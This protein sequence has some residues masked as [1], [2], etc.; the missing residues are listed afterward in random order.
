MGVGVGV[1]V[2][3]VSDGVRFRRGRAAPPPRYHPGMKLRDTLNVLLSVAL[4]AGCS[5]ADADDAVGSEVEASPSQAEPAKPEVHPRVALVRSAKLAHPVTGAQLPLRETPLDKCYGFKGYSVKAPEGSKTKTL[6]G[7][8]A[9]HVE[10]PGGKAGIIVMTDAIAVKWW[11]RTDLEDVKDKI[12][13]DEDGF[14][15]QRES[16]G[17]LEYIGW[18][19]KKIGPHQ[20]KCNANVAK[21]LELSLDDEQ[22]FLELCRTVR[23]EKPGEH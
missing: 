14:L 17:K 6:V 10:F 15:Y 22:G 16:K 20:V 5:Q 1:G 21:G 9:C 18:T 13:D 4:L 7:A 8:R 3:A 19:D 2:G 23:Y 11:K 12:V